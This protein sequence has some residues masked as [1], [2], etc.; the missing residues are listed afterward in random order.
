MEVLTN[1]M[2]YL[3]AHLGHLE[4][5]HSS[6][7]PLQ[8]LGHH[9]KGHEQ[10]IRRRSFPSLN[11]SFILEGRGTYQIDDLPPQR[12]R[13]PCVLIQSDRHE[14]TYGPGP[15]EFW[16]ELFLIYPLSCREAFL[17][18]R[19]LLPS[20]HLWPI[21]DAAR[22]QHELL[23]LDRAIQSRDDPGMADRID[24]LCELLILESLRIP[25]PR[26]HRPHYD[27]LQ[28]IRL[29]I[30]S[31]PGD[32]H[33]FHRLATRCG[34][35][36]SSFRR[37]WKL[38][39]QKSPGQYLL[40]RRFQEARRLLVETSLSIGAIAETLGFDDPL[41]FSKRFHKT[42]GHTASAYRELHEVDSFDLT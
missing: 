26:S 13:A 33:D 2:E 40:E 22:L 3:T 15:G 31:H 20:L 4:R 10:F 23:A 19:L 28:N 24:R 30:D 1:H 35:S 9:P 21:P 42:T 37:H 16:R 14:Y 18:S 36:Y 8:N 12:V 34:L 39:F 6:P 27:A 32:R 11:F 17:A 25:P 38:Y 41:Y 7:F 29:R 5:R